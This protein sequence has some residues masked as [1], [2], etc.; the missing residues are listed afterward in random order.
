MGAVAKD[1]SLRADARLL[2]G[3]LKAGHDEWDLDIQNTVNFWF[4][5]LGVGQ[6]GSYLRDRR[7]EIGGNSRNMSR[8]IE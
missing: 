4:R 8:R 7:R 2:G 5:T 3:R 1:V 6:E